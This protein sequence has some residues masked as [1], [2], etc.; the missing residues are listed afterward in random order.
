MECKICG[1][2]SKYCFSGEMLKRFSVDYF[3]CLKCDFIQTEEP[4]W[5]DEAYSRPINTSDT[6]YMARNLDLKKRVSL[7]LYALFRDE[8]YFVDYAG[9][10]GVFVRLMR[11]IGF[12]FEWSDKFTKNLFAAG[13]EWD[14][15]KKADALTLFEVFEHF[16]DPVREMEELVKITDTIVFSTELH[17][18]PCPQPD[19]WWYFG[20]DHGQ[21]I[22]FYSENS[23]IY[24]A[25]LFDM[26]YY[27][28]GSLHIFSKKPISRSVL[29]VPK[30][31]RCGGHRFVEKR[32]H[33]KTWSDYQ[34]MVSGVPS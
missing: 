22:S 6:G 5:L 7:L 8:G 26:R 33:S 18:D 27:K 25:S 16:V 31:I 20:L 34:K 9:G 32:M 19:E 11:D 2:E 14:G 24:L 21:H 17:P 12:N 13:F 4:Y 30:L 3:H 15:E 10:Y 23:L 29:W 28:C 1:A